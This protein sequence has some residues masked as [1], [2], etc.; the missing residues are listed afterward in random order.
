MGLRRRRRGRVRRRRFD[1]GL[2]RFEAFLGVVASVVL[3]GL[4]FDLL[5]GYLSRLG[6]RY[7][8]E[9]WI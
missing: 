7:V 8:S 1:R 3:I 6:L 4:G 5:D 9:R 2:R